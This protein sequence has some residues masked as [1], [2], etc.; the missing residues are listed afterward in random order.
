MLASVPVAAAATAAAEIA[1]DAEGGK[2]AAAAAICAVFVDDEEGF[3]RPS[4]SRIGRV[5]LTVAVEPS[6]CGGCC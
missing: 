3:I 1:A 6:V 4:S 5:E 2:V